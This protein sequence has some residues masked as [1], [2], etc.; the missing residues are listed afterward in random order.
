MH[1]FANSTKKVDHEEKCKG[2]LNFVDDIKMEGMLYAKT[3]R[4]TIS[5]GEILSIKV[6]NLPKGYCFID[7]NDIKKENVVNIIFDDWPIFSTGKINYYGEPIGLLVGDNKG[8]LE[9]L[10]KEIEIS[11]KEETPVFDYVNSYIHKA[12]TKGDYEKAKKKAVKVIK[13]TYETGF[14]E[15]AYL[16]PQGMLVYPD[17]KNKDKL[18]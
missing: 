11:Y 4:S 16:E 17:P 1:R 2:A 18:I 14:Q 6:P 10:A 3:I 15:Q 12:Y 5:K 7:K 9:R 8:E 13:E